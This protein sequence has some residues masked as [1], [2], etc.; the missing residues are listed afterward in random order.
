MVTREAVMDALSAVIDPELRHPITELNMVDRIDIAESGRLAITILLTTPNCP[1]K[2]IIER[3]VTQAVADVA[4]VNGVDV[5]LSPMTPAQLQALTRKLR[6]ER[7]RRE[8][9]FA[10]PDS[11]TK[12]IAVASG[13]GGVGKSSI[14]A[15][16]AA[17]MASQG[18]RVGLVD[19]DIYGFSIPAMLGVDTPAQQINGMIIPPVAHGVKVMS[20]G[21]FVKGNQAIMWRGPMLAKALEQFFADV[22]WGD[23]DVL[24]LDLPPG[25]GDIALTVASLLPNSQLLVTTTPQPAASDVAERAGSMASQ[26]GQH[27]IGVIENMS[28]MDLPGGQRNYLF[29]SGGGQTVAAVLSERLGY[30]VPLLGQ[31]PF[32]SAI[33]EGAD[34]GAPAVLSLLDSPAKAEFQKIARTIS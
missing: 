4:G 9:P 20:I 31:I 17:A 21:M 14:A 16:L 33:R 13:K 34:A 5:T 7:V 28:W 1:R 12:I 32:E 15:N 18:V 30:S 6:G 8:I 2:S 25:T 11:P 29:G 22:Y 19:A 10:A 26:T 23:L 3:E 24:L 27:V